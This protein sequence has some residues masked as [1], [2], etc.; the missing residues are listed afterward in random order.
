MLRAT[1]IYRRK[2]ERGGWGQ[3]R[4]EECCKKNPT[5]QELLKL[6]NKLIC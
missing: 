1:K 4:K 6:Q 3:E 2:R 5:R